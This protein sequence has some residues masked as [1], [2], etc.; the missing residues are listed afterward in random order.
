MITSV[1]SIAFMANARD[2]ETRIH[3]FLGS[4]Q[5]MK[6]VFEP[7]YS[8]HSGNHLYDAISGKRRYQGINEETNEANEENSKWITPKSKSKQTEDTPLQIELKKLGEAGNVTKKKKWA[9][10]FWTESGYAPQSFCDQD[11]SQC[12]EGFRSSCKVTMDG[13]CKPKWVVTGNEKCSELPKP[14][15]TE[16]LPSFL[17]PSTPASAGE[18]RKADETYCNEYKCTKDESEK[19]FCRKVTEADKEKKK[20]AGNMLGGYNNESLDELI[21]SGTAKGLFDVEQEA[22]AE[23]RD[24]MW[25]GETLPRMF[26]ETATDSTP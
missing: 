9:H 26:D 7:K 5:S 2:V 1:L 24:G 11:M 13:G 19:K 16:W 6:E 17:D 25:L 21:R 14:D 22:A 20:A 12:P 4:S 23:R 18:L 3:K 10:D 8:S 15:H